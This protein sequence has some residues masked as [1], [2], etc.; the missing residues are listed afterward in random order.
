MKE[1][2]E[3]APLS[4]AASSYYAVKD[5]CPVFHAG[6][7]HLFGTGVTGPHQFE[8]LHALAPNLRG[9]W[10][11][12]DAV[13]LASLTGSCIG[14]P[15]VVSDGAALHMFLQTDYNQLGGRVEQLISTDDGRTFAHAATALTSDP[16]TDEA[17]IYDPHPAQIGSER[18]LVYSAFSTIGE[19]DVHLARS[20]SGTWAGPW[21]KLGPI[22]RHEDVVWHNQRGSVGYE[23]GLEGAQLVELPDGTVLLNGVCFLSDGPATCR[24]RVF[25]ARAPHVLGPYEVIGPVIAPPADQIQGE[26]GHATVVL[27]GDQLALFFQERDAAGSWRY[28]IAFA[29]IRRLRTAAAR[30]RAA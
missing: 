15:G 27:D 26:N 6:R 20:A 2:F 24:Q 22:L 23:W 3:R 11:L 17:G 5:P 21:E 9:P 10:K 14:A 4:F 8:V 25:F 19:P 18:Y 29:P 1:L 16:G 7:W 12:H 13:A 28:A 30:R